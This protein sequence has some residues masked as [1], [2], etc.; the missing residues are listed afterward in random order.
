MAKIDKG[1]KLKPGAAHAGTSNGRLSS[2]FGPSSP[3]SVE[4]AG[5]GKMRTKR[6][7]S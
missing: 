5:S 4:G 1:K 3:P 6:N 7:K 2:G